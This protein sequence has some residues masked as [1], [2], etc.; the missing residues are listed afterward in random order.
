MTTIKSEGTVIGPLNRGLEHVSTV[1]TAPLK[2]YPAH[3][4][5]AFNVTGGPVSKKLEE[6]FEGKVFKKPDSFWAPELGH[7]ALLEPG[8]LRKAA[9]EFQEILG[10]AFEELDGPEQV[11]VAEAYKVI[12]EAALHRKIFEMMWRLLLPS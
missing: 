10:H 4:E 6:M 5:D 12:D 3:K 8:G 9:D 7:K 1:R 11:I 2:H